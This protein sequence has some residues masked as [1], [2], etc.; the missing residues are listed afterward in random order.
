VKVPKG[1]TGVNKTPIIIINNNNIKIITHKMR[2][3]I[4]RLHIDMKTVLV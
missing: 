3:Q 4:L 1:K 2:K